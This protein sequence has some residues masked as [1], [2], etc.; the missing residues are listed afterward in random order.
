MEQ[1]THA[2]LEPQ[3]NT[4][5]GPTSEPAI[6]PV[7]SSKTPIVIAILCLLLAIGGISF[8]VWGVMQANQSNVSNADEPKT[9]DPAQ[10]KNTDDAVEEK[11]ISDAYLLQELDEK[12]AALH[13]RSQD[14]DST[15]NGSVI[16]IVAGTHSEF[17]LYTEG[18]FS[19]LEKLAATFGSLKNFE[20]NL[21]YSELQIVAADFSDLL[22]SS[23]LETISITA[24][25]GD[26]V[27]AK[28]QDL[29]GESLNKEAKKGEYHCPNYVYDENIDMYV[30]LSACGGTS[31]ATA[32]YYK[33]KYTAAGD[34]AYVYVR[35][36]EKSGDEK[37]VYRDIVG[38]NYAE[39]AGLKTDYDYETFELDSSNYQDFQE[40]R[41]VF[42]KS[43]TGTYYFEKVEK[44][45]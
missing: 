29:F 34:N 36:A 33:Q 43:S 20:R 44:L 17:S 35:A 32:Y 1:D 21:S 4:A 16:K 23:N 18:T 12:I 7:K 26:T 11:S 3:K 25:D 27:S 22:P 41:F 8:G 14:Y 5:P 39:N 15:E 10:G 24:I 2:P 19:S 38:F 30:D 40:Y 31:D 45:S 28:Y 37:A 9:S 13:F 6:E 42:K